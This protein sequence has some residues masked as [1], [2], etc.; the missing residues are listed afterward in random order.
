MS[1]AALCTD[2]SGHNDFLGGD[3]IINYREQSNC[4]VLTQLIKIL[5]MTKRALNILS[6]TTTVILYFNQ[7][8][9]IAVRATKNTVIFVGVTI[10][11]MDALAHF[12]FLATK[13][14]AQFTV[15]INATIISRLN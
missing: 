9:I 3:A 14:M 7:A 12:A 5:L 6:N 13:N 15:F 4:F 10:Y 8:V 11:T 1:S 2:L